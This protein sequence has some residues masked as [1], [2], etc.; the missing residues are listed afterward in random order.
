MT[1]TLKSKGISY[2]AL[3]WMDDAGGG[4]SQDTAAGHHVSSRRQREASGCYLARNKTLVV[5]FRNGRVDHAGGFA[6]L[7]LVLF[8]TICHVTGCLTPAQMLLVRT[9]IHGRSGFC[10]LPLQALKPEHLGGSTVHET[11]FVCVLAASQLR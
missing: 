4:G 1:L 6:S 9:A 3:S 8:L 2:G 5:E 11:T 10:A 7:N